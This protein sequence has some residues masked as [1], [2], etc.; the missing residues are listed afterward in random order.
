M[1]VKIKTLIAGHSKYVNGKPKWERFS[2]RFG[3]LGVQFRVENTDETRTVKYVRVKLVCKNL[4]GDVIGEKTVEVT[5]PISPKKSDGLGGTL[6]NA[7]LH[8]YTFENL[9]RVQKFG[10][11]EVTRV[12]AEYTDGT[13]EEIDGKEATYDPDVEKNA[14]KLRSFK[15]FKRS[16]KGKLIGGVCSAIAE[17]LGVTP[18]MFRSIFILAQPAG[19]MLYI[20]LCLTVPKE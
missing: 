18:W 3:N 13:T 7:A 17:R 11:V 4:V 20:I 6:L 5:G 19:I 16:S 9:W 10:A 1:S 15:N 2:D 8:T 14:E 12:E